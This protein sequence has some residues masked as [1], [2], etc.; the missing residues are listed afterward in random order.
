MRVMVAEPTML[1]GDAL[2][3]CLEKYGYEVKHFTGLKRALIE[4]Y[5]DK[6]DFYVV[7]ISIFL[8]HDN[9]VISFASMKDRIVL[10][11]AKRD[12]VPEGYDGWNIIYSDQS[13]YDFMAIARKLSSIQ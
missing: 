1:P 8:K 9:L 11:D 6:Y 10:I 3:V 4:M 7:N 2:K 5:E 12:S 13:I